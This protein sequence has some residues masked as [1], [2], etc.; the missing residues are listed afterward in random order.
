MFFHGIRLQI[1]TSHNHERK[2]QQGYL[3]PPLGHC[4]YFRSPISLSI[5][6]QTI[7]LSASDI[8]T[9]GRE[10]R[11]PIYRSTDDEHWPDQVQIKYSLFTI[12][13]RPKERR[14]CG[15]REDKSELDW[16][17]REEESFVGKYCHA[18]ND[19][20]RHGKNLT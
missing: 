1:S 18:H 5:L 15:C 14:N 3:H 4:N 7:I 13:A 12:L 2:A 9:R 10:A 11:L 20:M 19:G 17:T 16:T 8:E 6:S